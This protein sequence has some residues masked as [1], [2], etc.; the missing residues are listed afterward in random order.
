VDVT[1]PRATIRSPRSLR[2]VRGRVTIRAAA[3]D[4]RGVAR[5]ELWIDGRRRHVARGAKL[6]YRWTARRGRHRIEVRAFDEAGNSSRATTV[7][8][9]R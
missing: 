8:V 1:R 5:I 6:S 7:A 2:K 9:G 4:D 3:T